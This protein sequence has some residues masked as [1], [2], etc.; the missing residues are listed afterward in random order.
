MADISSEN[1]PQ[2]VNRDKQAI[3]FTKGCYLGQE[4][5][6]RIDALGHVNRL[7][8]AIRFD[9]MID[10]IATSELTVDGKPAGRIT[11]QSFSPQLSCT[12]ALG[13]VRRQFAKPETMFQAGETTGQ[14]VQ[15]PL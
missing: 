5:V 15:L 3:S 12:M 1:L 7:F 6:A 9:G 8:V 4:T 14:I 10:A 2:E 13:Y 11:S